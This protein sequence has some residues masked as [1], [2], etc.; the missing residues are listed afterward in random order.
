MSPGASWQY[1]KRRDVIPMTRDYMSETEKALR[2]KAAAAE[3]KGPAPKRRA[4]SK[5]REPA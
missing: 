5:V 3:G 2:S 1:V 4:S